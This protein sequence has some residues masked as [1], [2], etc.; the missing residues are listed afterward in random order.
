MAAVTAVVVDLWEY[1]IF[2]IQRPPVRLFRR[3]GHK[4]RYPVR[5]LS[6]LQELLN[7]FF[8]FVELATFSWSGI[9]ASAIRSQQRAA[10]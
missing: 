3:R 1:Q 2:Y 6:E 10:H 8:S 7:L 9:S 4:Y 5:V